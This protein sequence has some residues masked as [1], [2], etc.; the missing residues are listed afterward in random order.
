SIDVEFAQKALES[1][2]KKLK[3]RPEEMEALIVA[4]DTQGED[5]G[6][7][8]PIQRTLDGRMQVAGKKGFPHVVYGK[9]F[10][11]KDVNK[12]VLK[13]LTDICDNGFE[14][15]E[16]EWVQQEQQ[17][18]P[19][20]SSQHLQPHRGH[21]QPSHRL[22]PYVCVNPWH[23][24]EVEPMAYSP[25]A[26][27]NVNVIINQPSTSRETPGDFE[28]ELRK[29]LPPP[30]K[31]QQQSSLLQELQQQQ[32]SLSVG[33]PR[34]PMQISPLLHPQ[35]QQL[36]QPPRP[37]L[38]APAAPSFDQQLLRTLLNLPQNRQ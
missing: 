19:G 7:C 37:Q 21:E 17:L 33:M 14:P 35:L 32:E 11:F 27:P 12:N 36:Q 25:S 10:R 26:D 22:L 38:A 1:L 16:D 30:E 3:D 5:Q 6:G 4:V 13:A 28:S 23:Y 31:P 24:E 18:Q 20:P 9:I 2:Y 8:V 34:V 29:Y 15:K